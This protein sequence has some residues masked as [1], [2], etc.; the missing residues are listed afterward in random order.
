ME[1]VKVVELCQEEMVVSNGGLYI[2]GL[3]EPVR[4][5]FKM[6]DDLEIFLEGF[7]EGYG[8]TCNCK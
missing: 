6:V 1:N 8:N 2:V 3:F 5:V 4:R 7:E